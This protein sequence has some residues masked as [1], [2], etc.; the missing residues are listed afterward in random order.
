M[1]KL[2]IEWFEGYFSIEISIVKLLRGFLGLVEKI[3]YDSMIREP[4]GS[5]KMQLRGLDLWLRHRLCQ[6]DLNGDSF[7]NIIEGNSYD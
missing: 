4:F 7:P 1:T 5:T 3:K 6:I 2:V